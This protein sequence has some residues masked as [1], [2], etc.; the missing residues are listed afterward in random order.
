MFSRKIPDVSCYAHP[1]MPKSYYYDTKLNNRMISGISKR[2]FKVIDVSSVVNRR[3][4]NFKLYSSL[5]SGLEGVELLF[6]NLPE[7]V[8]PLHFPIIIH[9]R[10][11]VCRKLNELSIS[12]IPW[13]A[14]YH[15][16]FSWDEYT[17]A[18]FLKDHVLALPVHQQLDEA[19]INYITAKLLRIVSRT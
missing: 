4:D 5:M 19:H 15:Q 13:W 3:R 7:G 9:N 6:Q 14:G 11:E 18:C 17:N 16:A 1:D 12:A 10:E 8:C 2:I